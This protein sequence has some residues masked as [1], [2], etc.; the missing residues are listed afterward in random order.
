MKKQI[1]AIFAVILLLAVWLTGCGRRTPP[2]QS[3]EYTPA[4]TPTV[5]PHEGEVEVLRGGGGTMWVP[6]CPDLEV[7]GY[8]A[9]SPPTPARA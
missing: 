5:D 3:P 4:P 6:E 9:R 2:E 7:F 8:T 1:S